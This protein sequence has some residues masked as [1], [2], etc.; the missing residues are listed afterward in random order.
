[1]LKVSIKVAPVRVRGLKL[2]KACA[3]LIIYRRTRKGA[4]IEIS[5]DISF[6]S[7]TYC[8]TRKGAWIE[9]CLIYKNDKYSYKVAP[10]R[11]RG[12]KFL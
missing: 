9:I 3:T 2:C 6:N 5:S 12:L 10:V 1:M 4:W 8:R 7:I 11:V